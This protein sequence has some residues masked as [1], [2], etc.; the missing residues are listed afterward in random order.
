MGAGADHAPG[1]PSACWRRRRCWCAACCSSALGLWQVERRT[2][3]LALIAAVDRRVHSPPVAAPGPAD[4]PGDRQG[5]RL[6]LGSRARH[7]P[8]RPRNPGPGGDRARSRLLGDDSAAD[9]RRLD[10]AGQ[11]RLRA[12]RG[13]RPG[14]A[15]RRGAGGPVTVAGLLRISEPGGAFL[16]SNDPAHDRWYSRDV[17][18]IGRRAGARGR[19]ALFHRCRCG[20]GGARQPI[21]GMTIVSFPNNH[22]QYAL[23]W[24]ALAAL[25]MAA[26]LAGA[27]SSPLNPSPWRGRVG[28]GSA[29]A[30]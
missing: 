17:A 7:L 10:S 3:K 15:P 8:S 25:A 4:W 13:S 24:F 29:L 2:E 26:G 11:S 28:G 6:S 16:H 18:A 14:R 19:G 12:S 21:G 1:R 30:V 9:R 27:A 23:T 5:R 22:L 20:S